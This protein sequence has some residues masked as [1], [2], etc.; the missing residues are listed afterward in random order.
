MAPPTS[1]VFISYNHAD[2]DWAEWIAG[3]I[4]R[5][6]Y[7]PIIQAWHFRP[8][9]DFVVKMQQAATESEMT[10]AVL[11]EAY[12]KAEFTQPEWTAAF[13]QDPTGK[14]RRLIPIRV[15]ECSLTGMLLA[16]IY[17]DLVGLNEQDAERVLLDGLKPSGRPAQPPPFPGRRAEPCISTAPFPPNIARLHGVPDLPPHYLSR[18]ENLAG[19]KRKLLAGVESVAITSQGQ[20]L[21]LQGMGGIGKT[22]LAAALTRDSEVRQAFP[23]GIYWLSIGQKPNLLDLQNQLL[24]RLTGSKETLTKQQEAKDAMREALEGRA[25]LVVLDDVWM[26]DHA[27]AFSVTA[28]PARLLITTR[29]NEVLVGLGAEEHRVHVLSPSDALKMLAE[30]VGQKSPGELPLEAADV[31][32]ECGYLPL[33]LAMIG[34]M[35]R[36]RPTAW[37]DA[38][39]R[40]HRADLEAV[41]RNFPGYPYPDLLRAIDVSVEGLESA[42][43]ERYLDLSVF[44]EDHP[45]PE[46]PL[47]LLWN[48]D[49]VDTRD[50]MTQLV[51]RSL[52]T[53]AASETSLI[54]HDLQCDLIRKRREKELPGLHGRLVD[55]WGELTKLTN[56]YA[57]RRVAW[58]L[59]GA[60]RAS[61]L[62]RL[63]LNFDWLQAKLGATNPNALIADYDYLAD[64]E[65][66]R[67]VQSAIRLSAHVLARDQRQLAAQLIGR[68]LGNVVPDVHALLKQAADR[69]IRPWLR[70]LKQS[71]TPPG[72][73]LIRIL[74]GHTDLIRAVAIAHV[75][76]HAISASDDRTLRVWD[77]ESGQT[78]HALHGHTGRVTAVAMTPDARRAIS[79]STDRTLRVWNLETGEILGTL[80]G[81]TDTVHVV[82][83][84][85]DGCR[86]V[87]ASYDD[88]LRLWDLESG[89]GVHKL[90]G[91]TGMV[92]AVAVTSD[93]RRAV[94]GSWDETLR[95]WDLESGQT[96]RTLRGHTDAV[97][98]VAVTPDGR[99]VL[100]GSGDQTLRLW[101]LES[102][103]IVHTLEGHRDRIIS[104]ALT[105]DGRHA[106]S[107][108]GSKSLETSTDR[109]LRVWDLNSGQLV[110]MLGSYTDRVRD[111]ALLSDELRVVLAIG[112]SL[113]VWDLE[114][115]YG[116]RQRE[117]HGSAV[118]AVAITP[119]GRRAVSGS[120]DCKLQVWDPESGQ[121]VCTLEGHKRPVVV[122]AI[123]SDGRRVFSAEE[124]DG[125]LHVW[126]PDSGRL[127]RTLEGHKRHVNAIAV[128]LD[129]RRAVSASNDCTLRVWDLE[130]GQLVRTLEGHTRDVIAVAI[131]PDGRRAVSG[132][133]DRTLRVWDLGTAHTLRTLKGHTREVIAVVITT[134]G[135]CALSA[136]DDRTLRVWDLESGQTV[137]ML[138]D[139]TWMK[140]YVALTIDGGRAVSATG[141][142]LCVWD[143]ESGKEIDVFTAESLI[144]CCAV[145]ADGSTIVAGD[146][147]GRVHLLRLVEAD[148][149]KPGIAETKI[150]L[151][152]C[153]EQ[154]S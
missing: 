53:W 19:L 65:V 4:E 49:D 103:Q 128:T 72:G 148:P 63:L 41:K 28:Q 149:T 126:D 7:Q 10:I 106:V 56:D 97:F 100:S 79:G 46:E 64:E 83:I 73:P 70:P 13:A 150:Q 62:R 141:G 54:L 146:E 57:W 43:R 12:L 36:L 133:V 122:V 1:K 91:H 44:P 112:R 123:T 60:G 59:N 145:V 116:A 114:S 22:V 23:D 75:A 110:R 127:V 84:S 5:G 78:V 71:L 129:G 76:R 118:T 48:L 136:S 101:D 99:R 2:R 29:N 30:W 134:D 92:T 14:K 58:H 138:E 90:E 74:E 143:L 139:C 131:T 94:S 45:I 51:A 86:A 3:M 105:S 85:P 26:I 104:A 144:Q 117:E 108:S 119:D 20:A 132:S 32:K 18:E 151:L 98:A 88:T 37:R 87:S 130:S 66:L 35:I 69:K 33:A 115:T 152:H 39:G 89:H 137:R 40:L 25:A 34:A 113:Q 6:G 109:T 9:E 31:A 17:I 82:A 93:G 121:R 120:I 135:R 47:R 50:C 38:L 147:S 21:G 107:A 154:A 27:N 15:A 153:K 68:L 95:V 67:L 81:H 8:G 142:T 24:G 52:A 55:G 125:K 61:E 42:D 111:L 96:V 80:R 16:R 77:L 124:H 102:G 140:G 11:S